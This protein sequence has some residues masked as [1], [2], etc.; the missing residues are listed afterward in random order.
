METKHLETQGARELLAPYVNYWRTLNFH[1][2]L[3]DLVTMLFSKLDNKYKPSESF[4][5]NQL[6]SA[7]QCPGPLHALLCTEAI[8]T[9]RLC[10]HWWSTIRG[11]T[12]VFDCPRTWI[13][14]NSPLC[15]ITLWHAFNHFNLLSARLQ[16]MCIIGYMYCNKKIHFDTCHFWKQVQGKKGE[17]YNRQ[18]YLFWQVWFSFNY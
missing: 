3:R 5:V 10:C 6:I 9:E 16:A 13:P 18:M 12:G 2:K 14:Q 8:Q 17:Y 7:H 1:M 15:C 4:A 11:H